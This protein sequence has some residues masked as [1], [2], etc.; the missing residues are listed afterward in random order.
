MARKER[1]VVPNPDGGWDSKKNNAQRVSKHFET[2]EDAMA[3]S[4]EKA[5]QEGAELI[6]HKMDGTIQNPNSYGNDQCPPRDNK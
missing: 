6:P 2:K 3:W 1:H 5:K 4:K